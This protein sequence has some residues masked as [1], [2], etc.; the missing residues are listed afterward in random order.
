MG[1]TIRSGKIDIVYTIRQVMQ[2]AGI[3]QDVK[4]YADV[5]VPVVSLTVPN[6]FL[7]LV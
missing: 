4:A 3:V 1:K 5:V 7:M 2:A 6:H